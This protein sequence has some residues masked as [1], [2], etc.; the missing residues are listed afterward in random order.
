LLVSSLTLLKDITLVL[1]IYLYANVPNKVVAC[2][3]ETGQLK[4]I[5]LYSKK[6]GFHPDYAYPA[7]ASTDTDN[8]G[9]YPSQH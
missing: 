5:V 9:E 3:A 2:F 4:K 8:N 6:V 7:D 1:P